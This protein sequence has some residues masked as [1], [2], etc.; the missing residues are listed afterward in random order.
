MRIVKEVRAKVK[1]IASIGAG[2]VRRR[3]NGDA[4][5]GDRSAACGAGKLRDQPAVRDVVIEN[6]GIA[7]SAVLA[8]AAESVPNRRNAIRS[9]KRTAGG[10]VKNLKA[11]VHYLNV[12]GLANGSIR[13][14]GRAIAAHA[15]KRN[16]VEVEDGGGHVWCEQIERG[17]VALLDDRVRRVVVPVWNFR[18]FVRLVLGFQVGRL[19]RRHIAHRRRDVVFIRSADSRTAGLLVCIWRLRRQ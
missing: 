7:G 15:R 16:T 17:D 12:L 19:P 13:I 5:V 1:A 10:F 11:L 3:G 9:Q 2:G 18:V 14:G 8:C 6:D 4:F